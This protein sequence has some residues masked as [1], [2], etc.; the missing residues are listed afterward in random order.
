MRQDSTSQEGFELA[1]DM[2]RQPVSLR[3]D[4][5]H[6]PQHRLAVRRHQLVE[7]R[8][9]GRP[10]LVAIGQPSIRRAGSL[11]VDAAGS[12]RAVPVNVPCRR[13]SV[14]DSRS[15]SVA[16]PHTGRHGASTRQRRPRS[17]VRVPDT[18]EQQ[19]ARARCS[20]RR[21]RERCLVPAL[22]ADLRDRGLRTDRPTLGALKDLRRASRTTPRQLARC[23]VRRS[24]AGYHV[25]QRGPE[26]VA[27]YG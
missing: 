27:L 23:R 25:S 18:M 5:A 8:A 12:H 1:V 16:C 9:L 19:E 10:T 2:T 11:F 15:C 3:V 17:R 22:L 13:S 24:D 14:V 4:L 26:G 21:D 6:V 7:R 20:R